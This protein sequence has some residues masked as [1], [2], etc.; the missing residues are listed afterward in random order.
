MSQ[1]ALPSGLNQRGMS[2]AS[3]EAAQEKDISFKYFI[4]QKEDGH[5]MFTALNG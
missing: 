2:L 5:V 4:L 3:T 1:I